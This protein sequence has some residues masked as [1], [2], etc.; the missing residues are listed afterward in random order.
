MRYRM[1]ASQPRPLPT[2]TL[3]PGLGLWSLT[4]ANQAFTSLNHLWPES[5]FDP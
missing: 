4:S 1:L 5:C 3:S 2:A